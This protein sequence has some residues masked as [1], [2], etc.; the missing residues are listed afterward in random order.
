[1]KKTFEAPALTQFGPVEQFT[2][3]T[4]PNSIKDSIFF[5]GD[6]TGLSS[7]DSQDVY[8]NET[9]CSTNLPD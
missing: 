5:N 8:C 6:D 9:G 2:Q 7:D 3:V 1:M 4:G